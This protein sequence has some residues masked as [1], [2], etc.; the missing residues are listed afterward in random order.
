[1]ISQNTPFNFILVVFFFLPDEKFLETFIFPGPS[2]VLQVQDLPSTSWSSCP[3]T[4]LSF[5]RDPSRFL[6]ESTIPADA[7][8][9]RQPDSLPSHRW[10]C[11]GTPAIPR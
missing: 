5:C 11:A 6:A 2:P 10:C 7:L 9:S 8:L 4:A 1:M 3:Q